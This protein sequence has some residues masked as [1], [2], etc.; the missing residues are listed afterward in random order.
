MGGADRARATRNSG[1]SA[2]SD[3]AKSVKELLRNCPGRC[4]SSH[5]LFSALA[6]RGNCDG[7]GKMVLRGEYVMNCDECNWY[8]CDICLPQDRNF[9]SPLWGALSYVVDSATQEIT[10]LAAGIQD[11]VPGVSCAGPD[12]GSLQSEEIKVGRTPIVREAPAG[13][14]QEGGGFSQ[15]PTARDPSYEQTATKE[16]T[17]LVKPQ[18]RRQQQ[19]QQ[20]AAATVVDLLEFSKDAANSA[21]DRK[22]LPPAAKETASKDAAALSSLAPPPAPTTTTPAALAACEPLLDF[23]VSQDAATNPV[24][25]PAS[26]RLL[27]EDQFG[28]FVAAPSTAMQPLP[29]VAIAT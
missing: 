26:T 18:Q 28:D 14:A 16:A 13:W 9:S 7:C 27:S 4:P 8:L 12:A 17:V 11:L 21:T 22:G 3:C 5:M 6:K 1:E 19:Q 25:V 2:G 24:S 29:P 15:P 10:E 20:T 23:D